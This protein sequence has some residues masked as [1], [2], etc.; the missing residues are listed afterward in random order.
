MNKIS[1]SASA[2]VGEVDVDV[3][4]DINDI[5]NDLDDDAVEKLLARVVDR[6]GDPSRDRIVEAAYLVAKRL[7]NIPREIADL[8]WH[9]HGRAL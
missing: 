8:F 9:V 1:V 2:Y 7:P 5:V 6:A 4:L 3:E